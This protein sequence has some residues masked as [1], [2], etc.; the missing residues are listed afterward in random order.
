MF[1]A[2][3]HAVE[4]RRISLHA[5]TLFWRRHARWPCSHQQHLKYRVEKCSFAC[6]LVCRRNFHTNIF[7][8]SK[9]YLIHEAAHLTEQSTQ[10]GC[11]CCWSPRDLNKR[12]PACAPYKCYFFCRLSMNMYWVKYG[13]IISCMADQM[14]VLS[15]NWKSHFPS[16]LFGRTCVS[17]EWTMARMYCEWPMACAYLIRSA[18]CYGLYSKYKRGQLRTSHPS[19]SAKYLFIL[20]KKKPSDTS[21]Q[22]VQINRHARRE[23]PSHLSSLLWDWTRTGTQA[24]AEHFRIA[25]CCWVLIK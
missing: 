5:S 1:P 20:W 21:I 24:G 14:C 11:C 4:S 16:Q 6:R 25:V 10:C 7:Y 19:P 12:D 23:H 22:C 13:I 2:I 3:F 17:E 18:L 9:I 15:T 8:H